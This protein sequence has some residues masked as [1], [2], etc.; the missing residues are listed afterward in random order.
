MEKNSWSF[1]GTDL[2]DPRLDQH[3]ASVCEAAENCTLAMSPVGG[4]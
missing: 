1:W 3:R 4:A 2:K